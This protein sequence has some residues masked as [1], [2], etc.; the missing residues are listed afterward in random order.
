MEL[1]KSSVKQIFNGYRLLLEILQEVYYTIRA[2][3]KRVC[4]N[5]TNYTRPCFSSNKSSMFWHRLGHVHFH[6]YPPRRH[7]VLMP[8]PSF[9]SNGNEI[10]IVPKHERWLA[11]YTEL[12]RFWFHCISFRW[13]VPP[14][15]G[16]PYCLSRLQRAEPLLPTFAAL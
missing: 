10:E 9:I 3:P 12:S 4:S 8:S 11:H 7:D 5:A 2:I 16:L 13:D 1:T 14:L 6:C 15:G